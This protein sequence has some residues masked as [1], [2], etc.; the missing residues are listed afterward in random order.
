[1]KKKGIALLLISA[2][3]ISILAGCGK[4]DGSSTASSSTAATTEATPKP[5][6]D[7]L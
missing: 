2:L 1:M 3:L 4:T 6:T 5:E 7:L